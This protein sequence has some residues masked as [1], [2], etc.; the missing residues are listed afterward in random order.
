MP[1]Y[2]LLLV[3]LFFVGDL[4]AAPTVPNTDA[5]LSVIGRFN[6]AHACPIAADLALTNAHV[7]DLRP[8]DPSVPL[9]GGRYSS[10]NAQTGWLRPV[11]VRTFED[12][13]TVAPY[14]PFK[15]WYPVASAEPEPGSEVWW[16]AYNRKNRGSALKRQV[17]HARVVAVAAG[18]VALDETTPPGSSGSCVLDVAGRVVGVIAFGEPQ[19]DGSEATVIVGV[20]GDWLAGPIE[21]K[22]EE[23]K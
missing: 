21:P 23:E 15:E 8:F 9:Y 22:K 12:L 20:W 2:A 10:P 13:A 16:V 7:T 5:I 4:G 17:F 6:M 3:T 19:Y 18:H 1:R 11:S 14:A